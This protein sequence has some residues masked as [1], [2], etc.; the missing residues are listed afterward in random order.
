MPGEKEKND[1]E[2]NIAGDNPETEGREQNNIENSSMAALILPLT[3]TSG[4]KA[5]V[6]KKK[7]NG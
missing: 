1:D 2:Q 4:F 3:S 6:Q 5:P 7:K